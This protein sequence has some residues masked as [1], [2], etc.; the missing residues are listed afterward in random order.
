[1]LTALLATLFG[2]DGTSV[3][4]AIQADEAIVITSAS[5]FVSGTYTGKV[6]LTYTD[7]NGETSDQ[8]VDTG[9]IINADGLLSR[10]NGTAYQP[11]DTLQLSNGERKILSI[12]VNG[13]TMIIENAE[14][15][16]SLNLTARTTETLQMADNGTITVTID[17]D[18]TGDSGD[19]ASKEGTGTLT[20]Q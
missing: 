7:T 17:M 14:R 19:T 20:K 18:L 15:Y 8:T 1:M 6:N 16:D 10:S 13:K 9:Y 2:C 4:D 5:Q 3:L 12:T 11:G